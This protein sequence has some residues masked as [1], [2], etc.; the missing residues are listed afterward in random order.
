MV[1]KKKER[2]KESENE[3]IHTNTQQMKMNIHKYNTRNDLY[4]QIKMNTQTQP[5]TFLK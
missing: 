5:F 4:N 1:R 3:E 2:K